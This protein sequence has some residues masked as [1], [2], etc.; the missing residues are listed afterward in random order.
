MEENQNTNIGGNPSPSKAAA[1]DT[2][3]GQGGAKPPAIKRRRRWPWIVGAV[4]LFLLLLL[5]L[6]PTLLSSGAGRALVVGQIN[7]RIN[8]RVEIKDISL[9]WTSGIRI[10]GLVMFDSAGRQIMQ[11]PHLSSGL[12]VLNAI[13]GNY[14]LGKT[15]VDGL[16]VLVSKEPD[17]SL[18]WEH[19]AKSSSPTPAGPAAPATPAAS[20]NAPSPSKPPEPTKVPQVSGELILSHATIT[21]EDRSASRQPPVY[22]RSI[23]ADVTIPDINGTLTNTLSANA[24]IGSAAPGTIALNGSVAAVKN[25]VVAIN[26]A[27]IDQTL[28][29]KGV[30]LAAVSTLMGGNG[31]LTGKTEGQVVLQLASGTSGTVQ[32]AVK[33]DAS[34]M[35]GQGPSAKKVIDNDGFTVSAAGNYTASAAGRDLK[36]GVLKV[37][38]EQGIISLQKDP[39]QDVAVKLPAS[40]NPAAT[41]KIGLHAD[42]K[43]LNDAVQAMQ[44]AEVVA[45]DE[46]GMELRSG[47]LD[48]NLTLAQASPEQIGLTGS[49]QFKQITVGDATATPLK[50]EALQFTVQALANHDLSQVD[51]PRLQAKGDLL[52]IDGHDIQLKLSNGSASATGHLLVR[53]DIGRLMALDEAY[54]GQPAKRRYAGGVA[55]DEQFSTDASGGILAN[56]KADL[57]DLSADGQ[58]DPEKAFHLTHEMVL[59]SGAKTLDLRN[60]NV[61]ATTT[62]ALNLSLKGRLSDLGGRQAIQDAI[63]ADVAYDLDPLWKV[64]LPL[65]T[66]EQRKSY[67]DVKVAGKYQRQFVVTGAYPAGQVFN[68]AV[69]SIAAHGSLPFDHFETSG[70]ALEK[71]EIPI[72]LK[73]GIARIQ[74]FGKPEGQNRPAPIA[75]NNGT[76]NVGG[77]F[78][79]LRGEHSLL[80]TPKELKFMDKISLNP[81]L[82]STV[83]GDYLNNPLFVNA[84]EADGAANLTIH[85]CDGLPIDQLGAPIGNAVMDLSIG[86]LQ[87]GNPNL[88]KVLPRGFLSSLRGEVPA[89]HVTINKGILNQDFTLDLFQQKRSLKLTGQVNLATKQMTSTVLDLP[90]SLFAIGDQNL[91]QYLPE[92]IQI[93]FTG[94]SDSP[95]PALDVN[96]IMQQEIGKAGQKY[97]QD[98]LLGKN[99]NNPNAQPGTNDQDPLKMLGGLLN[100]NKHSRAPGPAA[101]ATTT[102]PTSGDGSA[103]NPTTQPAQPTP[104]DQAIKAIGDL[105]KKKK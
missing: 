71:G 73:D 17:G 90:W 85:N 82:A 103:N 70:A 67:A 66:P 72:D 36:L 64:L 39:G 83:L 38:D 12:T 57:T 22:V 84:A 89:Y 31:K 34:V 81:V 15:Q 69:Q 1:S 43:R 13:R 87:L 91:A 30:D 78:V 41:G 16:D 62:N 95:I 88:A 52:Q 47:V 96:R 50:D 79:D 100:R 101:D 51:V 46:K 40:G 92:G 33:G 35:Q 3:P 74:Y 32:V 42:L 14:A 53:G 37:A 7:Q 27:T 86:G 5:L 63:T 49:F 56:G 105:F 18:N 45:R 68:K 4:L 9:G 80:T 94:R 104:Q 20:S 19:L 55:L 8:G 99:K 28:T 102:A 61:V 44:S 98:R 93:P 11:L 29:I 24:Q 54:S 76:L 77:A 75:C 21:Y 25:N 2:M 59:N 58:A 97:L 65:M 23:E 10:D 60:F 26:S 48:G 6:A